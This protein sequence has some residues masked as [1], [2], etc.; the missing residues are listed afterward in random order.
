[1]SSGLTP[2][3]VLS[4]LDGGMSQTEIAVEHGVSRQYVCKLAKQAGYRNP[5]RTMMENLPW[6]VDSEF[7]ENTI[8]KNVR[9]H[10]ILMTT[11]QLGESDTDHIRALYRKLDAFNVVVDYDPSYPALPGFSNLGGFAFLPRTAEDED[12]IIKIRPGINLTDI[13]Q[14]IWRRHPHDL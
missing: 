7:A 4:Q 3:Y 11:G 9:R 14:K 1:M 12:Y 2:E 8:Y 5:Y 13:G 10:G 6:D